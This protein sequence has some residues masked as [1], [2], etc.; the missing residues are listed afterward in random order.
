MRRLPIAVLAL[1]LCV[2]ARVCASPPVTHSDRLYT[3]FPEVLPDF[4]LTERSGRTVRRDDL[5]GK[6]WIASFFFTGCG[7]K[8]PTTIGNM[9]RLQDR[10]A[11][12]N[13]LLVSF[14]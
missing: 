3:E 4:A 14:S 7:G 12:Y 10:L 13:V 1:L 8:C 2:P 11:G 9:R 6:V 5:K